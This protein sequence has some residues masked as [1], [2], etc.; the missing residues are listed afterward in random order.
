MLL[1]FIRIFGVASLNNIPTQIKAFGLENDIYG[2]SV[3]Y[4]QHIT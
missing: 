1:I 3:D 4:L 2:K